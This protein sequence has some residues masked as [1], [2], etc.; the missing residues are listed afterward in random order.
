[1]QSFA[2]KTNYEAAICNILASISTKDIKQTHVTGK[3][4]ADH[5]AQVGPQTYRLQ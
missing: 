3:A 4:P 1:M 2:S 5:A